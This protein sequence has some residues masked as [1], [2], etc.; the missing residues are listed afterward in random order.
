MFRYVWMILCFWMVAC[1]PR[2]NTV[3][4][5]D[6]PMETEVALTLGQGHTDTVY[7]VEVLSDGRILS[8]S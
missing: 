2:V 3:K 7:G 1:A 6:I 8:Y 4:S 5:R